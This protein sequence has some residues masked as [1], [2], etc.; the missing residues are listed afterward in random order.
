MLQILASRKPASVYMNETNG[1]FYLMDGLTYL[2][3]MYPA[4]RTVIEKALLWD[5]DDDGL[6]ENSRSPDQTFDSWLM[7]GPR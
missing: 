3:A 5:Q 2:K 6:I 1:K 7:D 4:C